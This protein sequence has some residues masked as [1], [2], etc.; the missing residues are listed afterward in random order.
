MRTELDGYGETVMH[1]GDMVCVPPRL[2]HDVTGFSAD[3]EVLEINCP[4]DF[5]TVSV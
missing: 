5:E 2:K 4:A 3:F 1:P